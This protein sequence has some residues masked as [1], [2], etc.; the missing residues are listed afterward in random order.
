MD[1]RAIAGSKRHHHCDVLVVGAGPAGLA[2]ALAAARTGARVV[3]VDTL[4]Q[5]GGSLLWSPQDIAGGPSAEWLANT[6]A[7]LA[8][9]PK[10]LRLT[11]ATAVGSYDDNYVVVAERWSDARGRRCER[12][13][14]IRAKQVVLATGATERPIVFA[15]NDRPG[16][17]L[18]SAVRAYLRRFGAVAGRRAVVFTTNHSAYGTA[19]DLAAAGVEVA[20]IIDARPAAPGEVSAA[21]DVLAGHAVVHTRG[22]DGLL[23]VVVAP[24]SPDGTAIGDP[25]EIQCDL[26]AVSGGW[27]P[28][29]GLHHHRRGGTRFDA[30]LGCIV[31]TAPVRGQWIVGAAAGQF[32]VA[33]AVQDGFAAGAAAAKAAGWGG[34]RRWANDSSGGG[35]EHWPGDSGQHH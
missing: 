17:M 1:A 3:V 14:H 8:A 23:S 7:E 25:R 27:D 31:P 6:E 24:L 21:V 18:A 16:I 28:A 12:L 15:N 10:V 34:L 13:W 11:R 20:A 32:E 29:L 26:L 22:E 4:S 5:F 2:A 9:A 30:M 35:A 33:G 19:E